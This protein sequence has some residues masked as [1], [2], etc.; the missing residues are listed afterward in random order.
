MRGPP[1]DPFPPA[2]KGLFP[3]TGTATSLVVRLRRRSVRL[4]PGRL[5]FPAY[6]RAELVYRSA[7]PSFGPANDAGSVGRY[8]CRGPKLAAHSSGVFPSTASESRNLREPISVNSPPSTGS[9][10]QPVSAFLCGYGS[11]RSGTAL[12][13]ARPARLRSGG[14]L[15]EK[16]HGPIMS[17]RLVGIR[18]SAAPGPAVTKRAATSVIPFQ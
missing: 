18:C 2:G 10:H 1:S 3:G 13:R 6:R 15:R 16:L 8:W 4:L 12:T 17:Q 9:R 11:D 14:R 5:A 7:R